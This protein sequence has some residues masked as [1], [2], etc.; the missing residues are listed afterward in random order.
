MTA[1]AEKIEVLKAMI[2]DGRFHHAT[3]KVEGPALWHG[4][5]IYE[6]EPDNQFNGY[7]LAMSFYNGDSYT[8]ESDEDA[9]LKEREAYELVRNFGPCMGSYARG[10]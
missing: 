5:Y 3:V 1:H 2:A 10:G 8:R 7:R 4:L 6:K 9:R